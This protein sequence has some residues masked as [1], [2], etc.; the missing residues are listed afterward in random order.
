MKLLFFFIIFLFLNNCSFDNKSGIWKSEDSSY[1][2]KEDILKDF[3][4]LST[5]KDV[6]NEEIYL[7]GNINLNIPNKIK[8]NKWEDIY[9]NN[10]NNFDNFSFVGLN[11]ILFKSRKIS[12][13]K[14]TRFLYD[15]R[16]LI[17]SD[18][19]GNLT[20]FSI[21]KNKITTKFNFYKKKHKKLKKKL[22][23]VVN[24][25]IIFVAD[26]L[27]F[28]YAFDYNSRK[29]L[30]AK[31]NKIP[32]RSN[33]KVTNE[34]LIAADQ[35]NKIYFFN[36]INGNILKLIPTEDTNIKNN[37]ENNF[38]FNNESIFVLNTYGSL[39]G[40][41][42]RNKN[43][44]WVVNLNQSL[45]IN[46]SNLF[47]AN[48]IV[49]NENFIVVTSHEATYIINSSNGTINSKFNIISKV[50]PLILDNHLF[51]I[52][53]NN[54]FVCIDMKDESIIYSHPIN[55]KIS[56]F[57]QIKEK[58]AQF[59]SIMVSNNKILILL[60]NSYILQLEFDGKIQNV[61][62][63]PTKAFS[64]LIFIDETILFIN[65]KNKLVILN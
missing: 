13:N 60:Y 21:D 32:F 33:L 28:I 36:K 54:L 44:K 20:I 61:F 3:K 53:S 52:S 41:D 34:M 24:D 26:N 4:T 9:Y 43:V 19:K 65:R 48:E 1:E 27:G 63:L 6:F 51:L 42:S 46:P 5:E 7:S 38:S 2:K 11:N 35:N 50:K 47:N 55:K 8:N 59:K 45:D 29:V 22:N 18:E 37:F 58:K 14:P 25:G 30:W 17:T 56:E 15:N 40:I 62:K 64:D 39:Y 31:D 12:K 23:I 49:S 10:F 57:L 16:N